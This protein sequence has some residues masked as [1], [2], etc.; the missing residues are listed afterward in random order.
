[1]IPKNQTDL[2]PLLAAGVK[3]FKCFLVESGVEEF[4]CVNL[5]EVREA[6]HELKG[7]DGVLLFH[8]ELEVP[9]EI[10]VI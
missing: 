1:M 2:K 3:G 7:T 10:T 5:E 8:A 9:P 6:L 4:P